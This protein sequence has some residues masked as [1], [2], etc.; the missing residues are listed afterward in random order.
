MTEKLVRLLIVEDD[1]DDFLILQ[2]MLSGIKR[3]CFELDRVSNCQKALEKLGQNHHDVCLLDYRLEGRNGLDF[4]REVVQKGYNIP[5]IFLTGQGDYEVDVEAMQLGASDFLYKNKI[6]GDMLE[7]SIR[8]ALERRKAEE[9]RIRLAAIVESSNDAIY[10]VSMEGIVLSWNPGAERIYGFKPEEIGGRDI[11]LIIPSAH[12]D[13]FK[14]FLAVVRKGVPVSNFIGI[15]LNKMGLE[16]LVSL[17]LSPIKNHSGKV[18]GAS[19]IARDLTE[20]EKAKAVKEMLQS[21]RDELLDRLQLQMVNMPIACVLSDQHFHFT[22]W[23]PAAERL[24]GYTFKEVEGKSAEETILPAHSGDKVNSAHQRVE[25]GAGI[26]S[27]EVWEHRR[28]DG[29]KIFC[30]WHSTALRDTEG[31]LL[32]NMGMALDITER[33]KAEAALHESENRFR[34]IF[35]D[36]PLGM[37]LVETDS[38]FIMVNPRFCEITGYSASELQ[39]KS[40]VDI[41]HPEDS[42]LDVEKLR[43]LVAGEIPRYEIDKRYIRKDGQIVSC[44]LIATLI[45]D[46]MGKPL[47]A[48][49]MVEDITARKKAEDVQSQ[50]AAI[51]QQTP[52]AVIGTDFD[53][54]IFSWNRGAEVMFGYKL[55]EIIGQPKEILAPEDRKHEAKETLEI[56]L[57]GESISNFETV[58]AK[59]NGD[60]IDVS[61]TLSSIKDSNG[62]IVGVSSIMRDI[63]ER[64]MAE[65]SLRQ[66]EEQLRR[67]DKM[68][69]IGRLAGGVA[70]DFNNLLSVIGGNA[71]FL[72]S[73]LE[74]DSSQRD[75]LEEIQKAVKRGAELTKQLLVFGQK[76]VSKPQPVNLNEL[77]AEMRKMLKHLIDANVDL[78]ILQGGELK[79]VLADPGQMQ[80]IILNLVLNARDAMPKGGNLILETKNVEADQVE[81]EERPTLPSGSFVRLSVTDTGAGMT[82]EVQKHIFEPFFTTKAGKG[83]GLGLA[84]VYGLVG[85][86]SG[87][88]FVHSTPGMGTTFTLYFPAM[89]S[90]EGFEVKAKQIDLIPQGS[91][92]VLLAEDEEPVRKVL[93]RTLEKYGY[94]VLEASNGIQAVKKAWDYKDTIHLLLTDTIMPKMNGKELADELKKSRPKMKVIFVS[95]YPREVLSQQG[96]LHAG[97][98]LIQ[99]PFELEDLAREIRKILDEK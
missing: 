74:K 93:M 6:D 79:S 39:G 78:A 32:G 24:F 43:S 87:H 91:E 61:I 13:E 53:G 36:S 45:K 85:K 14:R 11:S 35:E 17:A 75:E 90:L 44:H 57:A 3:R 59:A 5:I 64:K 51:L 2:K 92:T 89:L 82:P 42:T 16:V 12:R 98:H 37:G 99:K 73:S 71:E 21:E 54:R 1:Q 23:N 4:L 62:K 41:T 52:D 97:I 19:V 8:Y 72:L 20:S 96:I 63:T 84:T 83:T 7:R 33:R 34:R 38:R 94:K 67:V 76:Q 56:A 58:R 25:K 31:N 30:E 95:G 48:M 81:K 15:H 70:H 29:K 69:A 88:I 60:L 49:G 68:N 80:Q 77:S 40:F 10:S 86:W 65:E 26:L 28:K 27:G 46:E 9:S 47:Y 66:H 18:V 50:L 22:Y 55:I